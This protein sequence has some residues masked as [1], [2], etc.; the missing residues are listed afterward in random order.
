MINIYDL[1]KNVADKETSKYNTE[2]R[3]YVNKF[4]DVARFGKSPEKEYKSALYELIQKKTMEDSRPLNANAIN[5]I[6]DAIYNEHNGF[7]IL[8]PLLKDD[9]ITEITVIRHNLIT[10]EK[11]GITHKYDKVFDSPESVDNVASKMAENGG[12]VVNASL[13]LC[14][15]RL[16]DGSR[17]NITYN[18]VSLNGTTISIRKFP[19]DG[20]TF[21]RLLKYGALS[22]EMTDYLAVAVKSR[23]NIIISGGTGSGKTSLLNALSAWIGTKETIVTIEDTAELRLQQEFVRSLVTIQATGDSKVEVNQQA[24]LKNALRMRPDRI[25]LGEVRD[26]VALFMLDAMNSGHEGSMCTLHA[27]D[28]KG[29]LSKLERYCQQSGDNTPLEAIKKNIAETVDII[30]QLNRLEDGSRKITAISEIHGIDSNYVIQDLFKYERESGK[31]KS[32][33]L[34]SKLKDNHN[35]AKYISEVK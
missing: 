32:T 21:D 25:I 20:I 13:P 19:N 26:S 16:K 29:A 31:F 24:L 11:S 15:V 28:V 33:G 30:V 27:N 35:Y 5:H 1:S 2:I 7:G 10:Y 9:S 18:N 22:R 6:V 3:D 8:E 23:Q 4:F 34:K 17:V 12:R 14:D